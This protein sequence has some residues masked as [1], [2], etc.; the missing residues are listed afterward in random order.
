MT[1]QPVSWGLYRCLTSFGNTCPELCLVD[2][3]K[4]PS[5]IPHSGVSGC[6][7]RSRPLVQW[8]EGRRGVFWQRVST[9]KYDILSNIPHCMIL[10]SGSRTCQSSNDSTKFN[11]LQS[12]LFAGGW[13]SNVEKL[14]DVHLHRST[15]HSATPCHRTSILVRT[16]LPIF[17]AKSSVSRNRRNLACKWYFLKTLFHPYL[18]LLLDRLTK[19]E[20]H[21]STIWMIRQVDLGQSATVQFVRISASTNEHLVN[22]HVQVGAGNLEADPSCGPL[23]SVSAGGTLVNRKHE[24]FGWISNWWCDGAMCVTDR[25]YHV[26]RLEDLFRLSWQTPCDPWCFARLRSSRPISV[27]CQVVSNPI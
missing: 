9:V 19:N 6:P 7:F 24:N 26:T 5:R 2:L 21:W 16:P 25:M 4:P 1:N 3:D 18:Y 10:R 22:F 11:W 23:H 12:F 20:F 13:W 17:E 15:A 8:H 14:W 27:C